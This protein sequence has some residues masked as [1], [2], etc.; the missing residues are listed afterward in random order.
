MSVE[1]IM[2]M[3]VDEEAQDDYCIIDCCRCEKEIAIGDE[4]Y[5]WVKQMGASN[6]GTANVCCSEECAQDA[7]AGR[8]LE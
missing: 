3:T 1:L 4:A 2:Q 8:D 6:L 7:I 5:V